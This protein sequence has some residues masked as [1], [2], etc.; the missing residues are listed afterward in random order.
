MT[1]RLRAGSSP[2]DECR[3]VAFGR[4]TSG[5]GPVVAGWTLSVVEATVQ[6]G[7][8]RLGFGE[9][10]FEDDDAARG[11]QRGAAVDQFAGPGGDPQLIAGVATVSTL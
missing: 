6:F 2:D 11:I 7:V 10:I 3:E 8:D 1:G 4:A 5:S 9:L